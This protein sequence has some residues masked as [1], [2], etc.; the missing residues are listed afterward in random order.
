VSYY[1]GVDGGGSKTSCIIGDDTSVIAT[2]LGGPSNITR[3]GE[4]RAREALHQALTTACATA[5]ITPAQIKRACI[6]AAGAGREEIATLIGKIVAE[7]IPGEIQIVGD[8]E[9]ALE[10][11]FG[12][13]PGVIVIA[14]TGS[15]AYGR[16]AQG[17]TA[18]A[19]GWGFAISD[20]GSAHWIGRTAV[21][22][23]LRAQDASKEGRGSE[24]SLLFGELGKIWKIDSLPQL[25]R[26]A[27]AQ[28]DFATLFPA[29]VA[30]SDAGEFIAK[31]VLVS[32]GAELAQLAAIVAR[33]LFPSTSNVESIPIAMVG[34]VFR[35]SPTVREVFRNELSKL[36]LNLTINSEVVD[37]LLG[38]LAMARS[39][40]SPAN[41]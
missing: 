22:A 12:A 29:V 18:R 35:H 2:A 37:P 4:A 8:M 14:G 20:E 19:G 34:G 28:P 5:K 21:S 11:A 6:G 1:L 13:G 7:V 10:A 3:I 9:I 24:S 36:N 25:A 16:D 32:A 27:N 15:I 31:Q 39:S 30:A 33:R 40:A 17:R 23:L 41:L 38:A 26:A